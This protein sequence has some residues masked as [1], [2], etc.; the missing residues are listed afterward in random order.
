[1]LLP[2]IA[3]DVGDGYNTSSGIHPRT[4]NLQVLLDVSNSRMRTGKPSSGSPAGDGFV[5][6]ISTTYTAARVEAMK[7]ALDTIP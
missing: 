2:E 5:V 3:S 7:K 1:M 6:N 4:F